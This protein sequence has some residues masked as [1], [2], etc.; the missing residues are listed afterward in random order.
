MQAT[1]HSL[2]FD[3]MGKMLSVTSDSDTIHI[4]KL[5]D[6]S[7]S[8]ADGNG[9]QSTHHASSSSFASNTSSFL[10]SFDGSG[11]NRS[12]A[13]IH[14][15][16]HKSKSLCAIKNSSMIMVLTNDGYFQ[17]YAIVDSEKG[18]ECKLIKR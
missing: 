16:A 3:P 6:H 12:F 13:R 9:K 1:I 4:F 10:P 15:N 5:E 7:A 17:Q 2:A 8:V 18:G 11:I 14:L